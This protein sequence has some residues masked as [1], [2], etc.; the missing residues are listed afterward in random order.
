MTVT[1]GAVSLTSAGVNVTPAALGSFATVTQPAGTVV[2]GNTVTWTVSA[3]DVYG[4]IK[5]NYAGGASVSIVPVDTL[6]TVDTTWDSGQAT[7]TTT[8]RKAGTRYLRVVDGAL[9]LNS[10]E[11]VVS[12]AAISQFGVVPA[13]LWVSPSSTVSF[14]I[15]ASD[16]FGNT[17]LN[18]SGNPTL[19]VTDPAAEV[20]SMSWSWL[21]GKSSLSV[22]FMTVGAHSATVTAGAASGTSASVSVQAY[23]PPPPPPPSLVAT[24]SITSSAAVRAG[25]ELQLTAIARD[26]L[27]N[28]VSTTI[29]W[30][31]T[32]GTGT[33]TLVLGSTLRGMVP[34]TVAVRA[35]AS[36]GVFAVQDI[37]VGAGTVVKV[38]VGGPDTV[39]A[40]QTATYTAK[41]T[42][43][44][45]YVA[46][47]VP[48]WSVSAGTGSAS[49]S[50]GILTAAHSG[51]ATVV[52]TVEGVSGS[53]LVAIQPT[54]GA[55]NSAHADFPGLGPTD[56]AQ[57]TVS[58]AAGK[59]LASVSVSAGAVTDAQTGARPPLSMSLSQLTQ[60][61]AADAVKNAKP[62]MLSLGDPF[63]ADT[64]FQVS[65]TRT[66][67]GEAVTGF[68]VP[69]VITMYV[70]HRTYSTN[71]TLDRAAFYQV[72]LH[73]YDAGLATWQPVP[74]VRNYDYSATMGELSA[75]TLETSL[76]AA[77]LRYDLPQLR[78]IVGHVDEYHILK[79][80]GMEVISGHGDGTFKPNDL[81]TREQFAK[82]LLLA[83]GISPDPTIPLTF[84][85]TA[86]ISEWA[87][88]Y[89]ATAV[90]HGLIKGMGNNR[91]EPLGMVTRAQA[92]MMIGRVLGLVEDAGSPT[93]FSDD[94]AIPAWARCAINFGLD[95]GIVGTDDFLAIDAD[96]PG[97]RAELARFLSRF[98]TRNTK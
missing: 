46:Q 54:A 29:V 36:N 52:A 39:A 10:G 21:S 37:T 44:N 31:K 70:P 47:V 57:V 71:P 51:T 30:T 66:D 40:G 69:I 11:V 4:N 50:A 32:D 89:V 68:R 34:G 84:A 9:S 94:S 85:D 81:A 15:T 55:T 74:T 95:K 78:D 35:T 92:L 60:S 6:A 27:G 23:T 97:T 64:F 93:P 41:A 12:H 77:V 49:I 5:T 16:T 28:P 82:M 43:A 90:K 63:N 72:V 59:P 79:L 80:V 17:V 13:Q 53:K 8:L 33:A 88:P 67:T 61:A 65:V 76:F 38:E 75:T 45:G 96:R 86:S 3:L 1:D 26:V 56:T 20:V 22:K 62:G 73:R 18:Y 83:A 25:S 2:A 19:T 42:D 48:T 87:R 58:D 91:F 14:E 24:V 7:V 98:V